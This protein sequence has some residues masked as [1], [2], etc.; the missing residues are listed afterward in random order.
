MLSYQYMI[1]LDWVSVCWVVTVVLGSS[2]HSILVAILDLWRRQ[3]R[4]PERRPEVTSP[5]IQCGDRIVKTWWPKVL[6]IYAVGLIFCTGEVAYL[7]RKDLENSHMC[8]AN[9]LG[10]MLSVMFIDHS[11]HVGCLTLAGHMCIH[12]ILKPRHADVF[13]G[14]NP[15]IYFVFI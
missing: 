11:W 14:G 9:E 6:H 15:D 10:D 12:T 3:F 8:L 4:P 1:S 13:E 5:Q 7:Y 2:C